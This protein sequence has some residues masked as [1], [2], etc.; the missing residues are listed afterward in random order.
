MTDS[1]SKI[2]DELRSFCSSRRIIRVTKSRRTI[3]AGNVAFLWENR[4]TQRVLVEK[5]EGK[6][7]LEKC[8][9]L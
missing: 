7:K 4:N 9:R 6:G 5:P 3:W 1:L 8:R 2:S